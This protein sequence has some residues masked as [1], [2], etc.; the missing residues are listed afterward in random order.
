MSDFEDMMG[1]QQ[2]MDFAFRLSCEGEFDDALYLYQLAI[3][4]RPDAWEPYV[5]MGHIHLLR[6]NFDEGLPLYEYRLKNPEYQIIPKLDT[7]E[8]KGE[9]DILMDDSAHT[10]FVYPEQGYGDCIHFA[11]HLFAVQENWSR[12]YVGIFRPLLDLFEN[13][14]YGVEYVVSRDDVP[15]H[16]YHI[17]MGS[18]YQIYGDEPFCTPYLWANDEKIVQAGKIVHSVGDQFRPKIGIVWAGRK[19]FAFEKY[20]GI[21]LEKLLPL[22][23]KSKATFFSLQLEDDQAETLPI[24]YNFHNLASGIKDFHDTAAYIM[25]MDM[26]ISVDTSV[27]HLAGALGKRSYGLLCAYPDWRWQLGMP[28]THLYP[29]MTLLR[30]EKLGDWTPVLNALREIL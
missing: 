15:E 11:R 16:D 6:G 14:Y 4:E 22:I 24:P 30:Q 21:P 17:A 25:N 26:I 28:V 5:A 27:L 10:L 20:R 9:T 2:Y 7:P 13:A 8:W 18:L 1:Y 3:K 29:E 23:E 12:V 19:D